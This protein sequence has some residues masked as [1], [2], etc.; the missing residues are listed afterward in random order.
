VG[1][2]NVDD[3]D[4]DDDED[5]DGD[6]D[7]VLEAGDEEDES[8]GHLLLQSRRRSRSGSSEGCRRFKPN[9]ETLKVRFF[10]AT[11]ALICIEFE[12]IYLS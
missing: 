5:E 1:N 4:D 3:D 10:K 8:W 7:Y 9:Q 2:V 12:S 11:E 6:I